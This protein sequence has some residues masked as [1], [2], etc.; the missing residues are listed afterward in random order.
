MLHALNVPSCFNSFWHCVI[1]TSYFIF[2]DLYSVHVHMQMQ[3]EVYIH[4]RP[5]EIARDHRL[6]KARD[7][8]GQFMEK[9]GAMYRPCLYDRCLAVT[10]Y[11]YIIC[12]VYGWHEAGMAKS[13]CISY[14]RVGGFSM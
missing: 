4:L 2:N 8:H 7:D 9:S 6:W 1:P 12:L 11:M 13:R 14:Q 5:M 3:N 10:T